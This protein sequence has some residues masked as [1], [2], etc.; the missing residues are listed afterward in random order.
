MAYRSSFKRELIDLAL[1]DTWS[2]RGYVTG[3]W[4][5][6]PSYLA[7]DKSPPLTPSHP[8]RLGYVQRLVIE[9]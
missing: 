8:D 9:L 3:I 7:P 2:L 4:Q 6:V 1:E 5:L